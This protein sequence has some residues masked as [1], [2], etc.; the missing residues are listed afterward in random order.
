MLDLMAERLMG[1]PIEDFKS[2]WMERGQF[3]E[4]EA[5]SFYEFQRDIETVRVGF[6]TNDQKTV[7]A[8]PDS[9]VGDD[10][11]LEIKCPSP[12]VHIGYLLRKPVDSKYYP[13]IQ[14]Q[15]WISERKWLD[16]LSY[17]PE[18]PPALVR[19]ERDEEYIKKLAAVVLAFSQTLEEQYALLQEEIGER[20]PLSVFTEQAEL[21]A[22]DIVRQEMAKL[23]GAA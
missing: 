8:S 3:L 7:G 23:N 19:V 4:P 21:S 1:H 18:I 10:G 6:M 13:Q 15:L 17:H 16:I 5:R 2:S 9:L 22:V 20:Q 14:G 12:G 11:L